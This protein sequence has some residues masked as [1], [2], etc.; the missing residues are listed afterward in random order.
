MTNQDTAAPADPLSDEFVNAVIQRHGYQSPETVIARLN[1]WIGLH[2]DE[3]SI[4]LLM[5]EAF[6]A[7]TKLRVPVAGPSDETLRVAGVIADKIEDGTLFEAGIFSRRELADKVRA[8]VRFVQQGAGVA[9]YAAPQ[10]SEAQCSCPS[11]DGSLRWPC[12][13]K[14]PLSK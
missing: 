9:A 14:H 2:G 10:A 11:G 5:Y 12:P 3:D 13:A 4:T 6:K 7:L 1:Q 8:V